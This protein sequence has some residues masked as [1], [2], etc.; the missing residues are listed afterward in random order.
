MYNVHI[1]SVQFEWDVKKARSNVAKHGISFDE[2]KSVFFDD[3]ARLIEDPS[4]SESE[5]R[6]LLIGM[7]G[8][9]RVVIVCHCIRGDGNVIRIIS[10]RR[11]TNL[12][13][14]F[15]RDGYYA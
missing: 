1:M 3:F 13:T 14:Q 15:Y 12:E 2:A 8:L 10:A 5:D 6:F 4:H 7:S 11:S 9:A